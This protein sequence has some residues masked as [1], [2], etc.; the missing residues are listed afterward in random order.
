MSVISHS[1]LS[2]S[3]FLGTA[4]H[5]APLSMGFFRQEYWTGLP[6]PPPGD[7]PDPGI[8]PVSPI[9]P[10]LQ[11]DS[12]PTKPSHQLLNIEM[13]LTSLVRAA[14]PKRPPTSSPPQQ[15]PQASPTSILLV[16][17]GAVVHSCAPEAGTDRRVAPGGRASG[18]GRCEQ[19]CPASPWAASFA[20]FPPAGS[21]GSRRSPPAPQDCPGRPQSA[22]VHLLASGGFRPPSAASSWASGWAGAGSPR[23]GGPGGETRSG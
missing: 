1:V 6:F 23:P 18:P 11:A 10:A 5:Q 2:Y 20:R 13:L 14:A 16:P 12:L 22:Q 17:I 8:K 15:L 9:A 19:G 3:P 4:A 7:L 21:P